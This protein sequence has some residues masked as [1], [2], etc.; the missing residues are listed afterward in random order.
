MYLP[1]L[2]EFDYHYLPLPEVAF[3]AIGADIRIPGRRRGEDL[4]SEC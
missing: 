3:D 2:F 1:S 4:L